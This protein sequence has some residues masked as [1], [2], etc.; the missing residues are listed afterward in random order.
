MKIQIDTQA[1][2]KPLDCRLCLDR[3]PEKVFGTYP[4]SLRQ[5]GKPA[6]DWAIFPMFSPECTGCKECVSFCPRKAIS[7]Q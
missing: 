3:C 7:V 2:D 6:G 4:R 1:C 5:P